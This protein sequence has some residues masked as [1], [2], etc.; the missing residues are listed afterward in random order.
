MAEG[1]YILII[2]ILVGVAVRFYF[3]LKNNEN[4]VVLA[5]KEKDEYAELGRGL[6]EYNAK[7]QEKKDKSKAKILEI[8]GGG[9]SQIS[10]KDI[11]KALGF[12]RTSV[13]RYL[14]EL[15]KEGKVKQVGKVGQNVAYVKASE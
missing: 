1:V 3:L 14:D 5:E 4:E 12:S 9:K 2:I 10:H 7:L 13:V 8:F 11:S 6:A 15:E